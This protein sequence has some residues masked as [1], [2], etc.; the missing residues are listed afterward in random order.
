ML[1][2]KNVL[3][4]ISDLNISLDELS[5]LEQIYN[6][7]KIHAYEILWLPIVD[8][9]VVEWNDG[10]QVQFERLRG[11]MPW[12]AVQHPSKITNAFLKFAR[13]QW[14]FRSKPVL[15]VLDPRGK[16][17]SPNAMHMMWIWGSS[18]FPFTTEREEMLWRDEVWRLELLVDGIDQ[19]V[20]DWVCIFI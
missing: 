10:M 16:V 11:T 4:L 5:I 8:R 12:Y 2:R 19:T 13:K 14:N 20:L 18:A 6:D 7:S 9:S 1:R 3:L 15:V 17:L